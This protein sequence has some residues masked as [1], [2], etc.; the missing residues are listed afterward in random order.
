[1]LLG[2]IARTKPDDNTS[3]AHPRHRM[4]VKMCRLLDVYTSNGRSISCYGHTPM[5]L[6]GGLMT[7]LR[8]P[9]KRVSTE[10]PEGGGFSF[11]VSILSKWRTEGIV[12][13]W[14]YYDGTPICRQFRISLTVQMDNGIKRI[15]FL[16]F[17]SNL[18][19][20]P[21]SADSQ[22]RLHVY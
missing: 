12:P 13:R 5:V 1:V 10:G 4:D 17:S 20:P 21:R 6:H 8:E 3:G 19:Q 15:G 22:T 2:G 14:D 9:F 11:R 16:V 18:C 7:A